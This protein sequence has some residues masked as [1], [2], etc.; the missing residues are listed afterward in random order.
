VAHLPLEFDYLTRHR[1]FDQ[2]VE[3]A[4]RAYEGAPR[5]TALDPAMWRAFP[6]GYVGGWIADQLRGCIQLWPLDGRRAADFLIGARSE[7]DLTPD[8]VAAV[9]NSRHTVWFFAGLIVDPEWRGRGMA[10]HLFAEAMLR[11]ERDFP[12]RPPVR[13]V[14]AA[15]GPEVRGFVRGFGMHTVRPGDETVDG[16]PLFGRTFSSEGEMAEVVISARAAADR[17]GRPLTVA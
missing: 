11:W 15:T 5:S 8:D 4:R 14:A 6:R 7:R 9:C 2:L 17:K 13:F 3:L 12:W 16:Y 1:S 10:A